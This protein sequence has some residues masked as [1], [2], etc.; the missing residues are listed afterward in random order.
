MTNGVPALRLADALQVDVLA[1]GASCTAIV[2]LAKRV[3]EAMRKRRLS[4]LLPAHV[5]TMLDAIC[6]VARPDSSHGKREQGVFQAGRAD[7]PSGGS[8]APSAGRTGRISADVP[9]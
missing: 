8:P 7:G 3:R 1:V 9:L 4:S 2:K 5:P 6:Q